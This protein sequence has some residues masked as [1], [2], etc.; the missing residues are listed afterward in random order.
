MT[1]KNKVSN[2]TIIVVM[3]IIA[4]AVVVWIWWKSKKEN[5]LAGTN[6]AGSPQLK[7]GTGVNT[8]G[9]NTSTTPL[10]PSLD[11]NLLLRKGSNGPEVVELQ[12]LLNNSGWS[13]RLAEDGIFGS[14]TE[15][16]L[17]FYKGQTTI[18]L[19]DIPQFRDYLNAVQDGTT[20]AS[21]NMSWYDY[22]K[23]AHPLTWFD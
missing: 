2:K 21:N 4:L 3:V 16:A 1:T 15:E 7:P 22:L 6:Y 23:Y 20:A 5:E 18:R 14:K 10:T 8:A 12:K 19:K 9:V 11:F 17:R 13:P